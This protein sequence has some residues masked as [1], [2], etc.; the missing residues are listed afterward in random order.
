MAG[1]FLLSKETNVSCDLFSPPQTM[2][3]LIFMFGTDQVNMT[4]QKG[5]ELFQNLLDDMNLP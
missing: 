4:G 2:S 5:R 1:R 3:F